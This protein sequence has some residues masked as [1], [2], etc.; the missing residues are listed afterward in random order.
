MK[1]QPMVA[2]ITKDFYIHTVGNVDI[3]KGVI[4]VKK[5]YIKEGDKD[6][7]FQFVSAFGTTAE[8]LAKYGG[9]GQRIFLKEWY[10]EQKK[11]EDTIY[12]DFVIQK[13]DILDKKVEVSSN[14]V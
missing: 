8:Y 14:N 4:A 5:E 9:K 3:A 10:V 12:Y 2:M 11:V 13:A 7:S 6:V 1:L